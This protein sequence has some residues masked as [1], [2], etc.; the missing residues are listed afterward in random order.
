[1][2]FILHAP[3]R[4]VALEARSSPRA[5]RTDARPVTEVLGALTLRGI[6]RD[7]WRLG[8]VVTRG[9]EVE[10]LAPCVWAVPDGRLFGPAG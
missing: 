4:V 3:D 1:M 2:D 5:H 9:C 8:L 10:P 6:A 7:A